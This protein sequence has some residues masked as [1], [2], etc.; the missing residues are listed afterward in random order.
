MELTLFLKIYTCFAAAAAGLVMGSFLNCYAIR[1]VK[2]EPIARGR[3]HCVECGHT[4]SAA[5]LVPLFSWLFLKGRCR[6]CG[7]KISAEYPLSELICAIIFVSFILKFGIS[8]KL[9]EMLIVASITFCIAICDIKDYT[10]PDRL[11]IA[12]ILCR[13]VF[14]LFSGDMAKNALQSLIGGLSISLPLLVIVILMEKVL[15]KEAMGGGDIKL[16]FMT[17]LYFSWQ[18]N[19]LSLILACIAGICI[20]VGNLGAGTRRSLKPG[21]E[22]PDK[23]PGA[24]GRTPEVKERRLIPFGPA[25]V[26]GFFMGALFGEQVISAYLGM[27]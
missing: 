4:L 9:L 1:L 22:S 23:K 6:Y 11:I 19:L 25:I 10:I 5:D 3:S 21:D 2:G 8:I 20:G 14:V 16:F 7:K 24:G 17:G 15:K 26:C 27:F 12:G 18:V 13:A